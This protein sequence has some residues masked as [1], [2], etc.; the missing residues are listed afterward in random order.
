MI[1]LGIE[2]SCDETA[3]AVVDSDRRIRANLVLSQLDEHRPF[4]GVVPE[5]AAR[6][7]LDHLDKLIEAAMREAGIGFDALD[8]VVATGGPG[9][10]GGVIVGAMTA[11]AIAA[12]HRKPFIAVNHLEGHALT[13]RL[14]DNVAFPYL[15]LLVSG[16]HCQLLVVEGVGRY[17][18]L[19]A[20]IDDAVGEA[21][22]KAAKLLGL[23]YPGGPAVERAAKAAT[24]PV[25]DLPRPMK[26]RADCNFS[27]SGLKTALRQRVDALRAAGQF[28]ANAQA[29][30]A[31]GFQLAAID[32]L[33]D[34]TRQ[35]VRMARETTPDLTALVVAGGVAA[36]AA[37]RQR[38]SEIAAAADLALL[39]PPGKLCTDNAAMIAWAGLERLRL[40]D[41][42]PL[43]FAPRPRW[44][45]DQTAAPLSGAGVKA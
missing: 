1:V 22:D 17:R 20:T 5:V 40:G 21:F 27:F 6:S 45:L 16:G 9:L 3:A 31:A 23:G 12:V 10:I 41:S 14:T 37:L 25:L 39:A 19:G 28:D 4:G 43:D 7:H 38:L 29:N 36:N 11:K 32:S 34:R 35:A 26:G 2:S 30:L 13:A 42:S 8:G 18:R 44:P 15:L 24:A 33:A